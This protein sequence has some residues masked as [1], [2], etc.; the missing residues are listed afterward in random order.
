MVGGNQED[1][2]ALLRDKEAMIEDYILHPTTDKWNDILT[3]YWFGIIEYAYSIVNDPVLAHDCSVETF[4]KALSRISLFDPSK[5]KF[6]TWLWTICRNHCYSALKQ[7]A[8][9]KRKAPTCSVDINDIYESTM[10]GTMNVVR[11]DS[12]YRDSSAGTRDDSV[13]Q[14]YDASVNAIRSMEGCEGEILQMRLLDDMKIV[15]ISRTLNLNEST[16]KSILYKGR[17]KLVSRLKAD[18]GELYEDYAVTD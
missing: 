6:S 1:T 11:E 4:D 17:R 2:E 12:V 13:G 5:G 9:D 18:F 7:A 15:D 10:Y 16:V 8:R 14:L 3:T